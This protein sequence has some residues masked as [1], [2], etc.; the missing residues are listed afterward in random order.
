VEQAVVRASHTR[1]RP[2]LMT[3]LATVLG[4]MPMALGIGVGAEANVP[5]ARAVIG[6]LTASTVLTL[7]LIPSLYLAVELRLARRRARRAKAAADSE[8]V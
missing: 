4:L 2:I 3:T 8:T 5:L 7:I 1:L 6:G